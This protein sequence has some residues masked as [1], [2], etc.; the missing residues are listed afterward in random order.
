MLEGRVRLTDE[1]GVAVEYGPGDAFVVPAGF[2]G[3]WE[4][5]EPVRK[6]YVIYEPA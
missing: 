6:R 5:L 2:T 3:T 1:H 4:S